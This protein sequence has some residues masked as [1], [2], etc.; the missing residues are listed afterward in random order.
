MGGMFY[1]AG[2]FNQPL[3]FDSSPA[4]RTCTSCST[5]A[6]PRSVSVTSLQRFPMLIRDAN[7]NT[8]QLSMS[9]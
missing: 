4:S 5:C 9:G 8:H 6:P 7:D 1:N 3:S 2:A